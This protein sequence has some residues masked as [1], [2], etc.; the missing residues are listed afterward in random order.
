MSLE[1]RSMRDATSQAAAKKGTQSVS[2][3]SRGAGTPVGG[4]G[5]MVVRAALNVPPP[6]QEENLHLHRHTGDMAW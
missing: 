3:W 1:S 2:S 4:G 5:G 6:K